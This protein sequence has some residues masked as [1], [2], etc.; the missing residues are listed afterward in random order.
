MAS[1]STTAPNFPDR[2]ALVLGEPDGP[3]LNVSVEHEAGEELPETKH[4]TAQAHPGAVAAETGKGLRLT[5]LIVGLVACIVIGGG[6]F[7][8]F[9]ERQSAEEIAALVQRMSQIPGG[10]TGC[11]SDR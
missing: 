6:L 1:G 2:C 10:R 9:Q 4:Y 11:R 8:Y 7:Y 3:R 5:R